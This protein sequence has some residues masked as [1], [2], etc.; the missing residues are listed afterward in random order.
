MFYEVDIENQ[1]KYGHI[2]A[3]TLE[4]SVRMSKPAAEIYSSSLSGWCASMLA[5]PRYA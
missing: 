4:K 1:N 5:H 2:L 3:E